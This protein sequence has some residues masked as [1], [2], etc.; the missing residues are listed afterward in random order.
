[1]SARKASSATFQN[2]TVQG[3]E[4]RLALSWDAVVFHKNGIEFRSAA[5]FA[6]WAEMTVTL[7]SGRDGSKV[8]CNGVV[9]SCTGNKHFGYHIS[10][11][12]TGL[13]RQGEARLGALASSPLH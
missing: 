1:M 10:M 4:A 5:P 12:L 11:V 7:R 6:P 2:V 3:R 8:H 9:I 13:S